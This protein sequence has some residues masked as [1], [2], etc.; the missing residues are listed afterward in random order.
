MFLVRN[1]KLTPKMLQRTIY[2]PRMSSQALGIASKAGVTPW[3]QKTLQRLRGSLDYLSME[4]VK[5]RTISFRAPYL[6]SADHS[7]EQW[8]FSYTLSN[9]A[10]HSSFLL[11]AL[12]YLEKDFLNLRLFAASGMSLSIIF[13][14]YREKPLWIPIRWNVLFL[15]INTSMVA[16]LLMERAEADHMSPDEKIL[17]STFFE[18][19][20]KEMNRTQILPTEYFDFKVQVSC[21]I[22]TH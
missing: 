12:S 1:W 17:Y 7:A 18:K 15:L 4:M 21:C 19:R 9:I 2:I 6:R 20:G 8:K 3:L 16:A 11:L 10:G 5:P 22:H 13:Q 14:Y